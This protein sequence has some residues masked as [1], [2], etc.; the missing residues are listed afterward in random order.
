MTAE[1][2]QDKS[3]TIATKLINDIWDQSDKADFNI[4]TPAGAIAALQ[5]GIDDYAPAA[6]GNI[7]DKNALLHGIDGALD[8]L[9]ASQLLMQTNDPD[10]DL[11][12]GQAAACLKD[13]IQTT[14]QGLKQEFR[15]Q[16]N[17]D[18]KINLGG[19]RS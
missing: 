8:R 1:Q 12:R 5:K 18:R 14:R 19:H 3:N 17:A 11:R 15:Q 9:M 6:N 10:D 16:V 4:N 2:I 13:G 7:V